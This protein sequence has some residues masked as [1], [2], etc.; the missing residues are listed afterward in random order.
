[1]W[2]HP[3]LCPTK[4][5]CALVANF[6]RLLRNCQVQLFRNIFASQFSS[7]GSPVIFQNLWEI[8]VFVEHVWGLIQTSS[9]CVV[10]LLLPY[11]L[12]LKLIVFLL[13]DANQNNNEHN[14]GEEQLWWGNGRQLYYSNCMVELESMRKK[15]A[16]ASPKVPSN[17]S[18]RRVF[19]QDHGRRPG[20][21]L[22]ALG[23]EL[24]MVGNGGLNWRMGLISI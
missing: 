7:S 1:M 20:A 12:A 2:C 3:C 10:R 5:Q 21:E 19:K 22:K 18:S 17:L 15:M 11:S 9:D 24:A 23:S 6:N 14:S 8:P 4:Q 16:P 13:S